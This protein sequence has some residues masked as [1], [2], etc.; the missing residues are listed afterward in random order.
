LHGQHK[1]EDG[2]VRGRQS[3][4]DLVC[5][6]KDLEATVSVLPGATMDHSPLVAAVTVNRVAPT[7]RSMKRRNFKA[8]KRPTLL[9]ALV[10]WP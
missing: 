4:L 10:I 2:E 3:V 1:R 9:Q 8:L 6:T 7:S 5:V